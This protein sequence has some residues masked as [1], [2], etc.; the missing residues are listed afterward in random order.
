VVRVALERLLEGDVVEVGRGAM[1]EEQQ[2]QV[3]RTVA[4]EGRDWSTPLET[5]QQQEVVRG[6]QGGLEQ[7]IVLRLLSVVAVPV[8]FLSSLSRERSTVLEVS[9]AMEQTVGRW[10]SSVG[11]TESVVVV[12]VVEEA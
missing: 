1:S 5:I 4:Q 2:D 11:I 7:D 12:E 8:V 10:V 6:I 3:W 9:R